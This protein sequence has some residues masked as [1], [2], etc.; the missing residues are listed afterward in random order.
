MGSNG[1]FVTDSRRIVFAPGL[2]PNKERE[3]LLHETLH[4]IIDVALLE[5]EGAAEE[6]VVKAITGPLLNLI[7]QN[8]AFIA[9]LQE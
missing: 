1:H 7:R 4:A 9:Y 3:V 6:A 5:W 2:V 8:K